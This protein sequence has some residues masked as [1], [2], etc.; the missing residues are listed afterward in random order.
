[1]NYPSVREAPF[2]FRV[3]ERSAGK[4]VIVYRRSV[5]GDRNDRLTAVGSIGPLQFTAGQ[6][7]LRVAAGH[8]AKNKSS[9]A[10]LAPGPFIPLD[11]DGGARIACYALI[12]AGLRDGTRLAR[13]AEALRHASGPEA[14]WWLGRLRDDR[15]ARALRALRILTE[16]TA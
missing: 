16:A 12:G 2:A 4:A 8:C 6:A 5:Q 10:K 1:M 3:V 15:D 14:A 9:A 11:V 7:L 13:A